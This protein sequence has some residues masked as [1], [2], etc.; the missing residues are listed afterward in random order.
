MTIF[1]LNLYQIR[2][3]FN[4]IWEKFGT[5]ILKMHNILIGRYRE[6][7]SEGYIIT[8]ILIFIPFVFIAF[9]FI[10]CFLYHYINS[11][12]TKIKRKIMALIYFQM[13]FIQPFT[14]YTVTFFFAENKFKFSHY[15]YRRIA[16][17]T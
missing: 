7:A 3:L 8:T 9:Y 4:E 14:N 15:A 13:L 11:Q 2:Q 17:M 12:N 6:N 16:H 10:S 5:S 1:N